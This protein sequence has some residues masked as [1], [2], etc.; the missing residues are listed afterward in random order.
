MKRTLPL[1]LL[2]L[3]AIGAPYAYA[4]NFG[5]YGDV[6][7]E[8]AGPPTVYQLTSDTSGVGYAGIYDLIT[9]M[10]TV[11]QLVDLEANY[12]MT[13]ATFGGGAPRFS[14][15]DTT[16]N[17]NNEAY[18]YWGTPTGGGSFSDPNAGSGT[19]NGTGNYA[20]LASADIRVYVN[21]FDGINTPNTGIT[22]AQFVAEAGS[23]DIGF[24]SLDLDGGFT[25]TQQML[26]DSFTV[27]GAV[28]SNQAP[29]VPEPS[30]VILLFTMI[31][32]V[33]PRLFYAIV[34]WLNDVRGSQRQPEWRKIIG[35]RCVSFPLRRNNHSDLRRDRPIEGCLQ[36]GGCE[37]ASSGSWR[38]RIAL[39]RA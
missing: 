17:T 11:S 9:G 33:G 38:K 23:T 22:W 25:G 39:Y 30:A 34:E 28:L 2:A 8:N 37:G 7:V 4:D 31:A 24:I 32:L 13:A 15:G 3:A 16:N 10:L 14:I 21:G 35:S 18:I 29:P 36:V 19:L 26:V 12:E 20:D 27:N 1:Y 5:T 6:S